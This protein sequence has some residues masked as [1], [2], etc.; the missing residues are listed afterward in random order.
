MAAPVLGIYTIF[1]LTCAVFPFFLFSL[2][3]IMLN[4]YFIL[5]DS[6]LEMVL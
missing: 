5:L 2:S 3:Q 1:P 4:Y 6:Y